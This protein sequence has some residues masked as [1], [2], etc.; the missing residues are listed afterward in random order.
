MRVLL[1]AYA[2]E[3][4]KGSEQ[5][6]GWQRAL[7]M[8]QFADEVWVITRFNNKE[9]I[10]ADPMSKAPGLHFIYFDLPGWMLRL[11]RRAWFFSIYVVLWQR[12]AYKMAA[13][14]HRN[15]PFD[16]VYHVTFASMQYGCF[17]SRLG[18]PLVIGPIAG[19]ER[20]P[21]RLRSSMPIRGK[22]SE[23]LRDVGI[24]IQRHSPLT[25][26][27]YAAAKCIFVATPDSLR[28][29]PS[30][31]RHKTAVELAIATRGDS[32]RNA[33][34]WPPR[35]PRFVF[36]GR[37]LH[38]KGVHF[39]IR[40][41]AEARRVT[42]S[43]TLTLFGGGPDE[44]WLRD[45]AQELDVTEAVEFLGHVAHRQLEESLP[46]FTAFVFPSLHD[47]G[48]LAVLEALSKGVPVVCL[49]RGGPGIMVNESCG[50]IISTAQ[51]D[52]AQTVRKLSNAMISLATMPSAGLERLAEGAIARSNELSWAK[53]TARIV[54]FDKEKII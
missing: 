30:R 45:L 52:E 6:V 43:A 47:S 3:P 42:P 32:V 18:I 22:F 8:L 10:E 13:R 5:E 9:I 40:A 29:V 12:G 11:K 20:T 37:L 31:W 24:A 25:Y 39:A 1:S 33:A 35:T 34:D 36:A 54:N 4:G 41:L 27:A 53:L 16:I 50:I 28:L 44:Q 21:F 7:H 15:K 19:G 14:C 38:W 26:P 48:G 2:C 49:D 23:L 46:R 51:A 17:M